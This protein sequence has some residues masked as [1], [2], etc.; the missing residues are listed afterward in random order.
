MGNRTVAWEAYIDLIDGS[1]QAADFIVMGEATDANDGPPVDSYDVPKHPPPPS[2]Y[3]YAFFDDGLAYPY[4]RL[5]YDYRHY[6]DGVEKQWNLTVQWDLISYPETIEFS[7]SIGDL[8]PGP[9]ESIFLR[10]NMGIIVADM[11]AIETYTLTVTANGMETF[12]ITC[13]NVTP[14]LLGENCFYPNTVNIDDDLDYIESHSTI[15]FNDD[16]SETPL[17]NYDDGFDTIYMLIVNTDTIVDIIQTPDDSGGSTWSSIGL[18]DD[19]PDVGVLLASDTGSLIKDTDKGTKQILNYT[20][21][22]SESPYFL[23]C[24]N[25]PTPDGYDYDLTIHR[26]S[27]IFVNKINS[28]SDGDNYIANVSYPVQVEVC[29]CGNDETNIPVHVTIKN[30]DTSTI[31]YDETVLESLNSGECDDVDFTDWFA[32]SGNY[33]IT[34][35]TELLSDDNTDNDCENIEVMIFPG[36]HDVGVINVTKPTEHVYIGES[37]TIEAMVCNYGKFDESSIPVHAEVY[38]KNGSSPSITPIDYLE[39][40]EGFFPPTDWA[41]INNGGTCVWERNDV[42]A[43]SNIAGSG[44]CAVADSDWCG[45]GTSMDTD[46]I[47]PS[48][49]LTRLSTATLEFDYYYD[50]LFGDFFAVDYSIDSGSTWL[51]IHT[52]TSDANGHYT[53]DVSSAC[54]NDVLFKWHY[55]A[56]SWD[57]YAL[58]DNVHFTANP[59]EIDYPISKAEGDWELVFATDA[60][61]ALLSGECGT[62]SL[63]LNWIPYKPGAYRIDVFTQLPTD[64]VPENDSASKIVSVYYHNVFNQRTGLWYG[65]IQ[66]AVDAANPGDELRAIDTPLPDGDYYECV[67]LDKPVTIMPYSQEKPT[68]FA[69]DDPGI[70]FHIDVEDVEIF[71]F[72]IVNADIGIFVDQAFNVTINNCTIMQNN[73]GIRLTGASASVKFNEFSYNN[74]S[75]SYYEAPKSLPDTTKDQ[76]TI[77]FEGFEGTWINDP[78]GDPYMVPVDPDYGAWDIDGL[79]TSTQ[80]GYPQLTHYITQMADYGGYGIP[81]QGSYCAGAWWSDGNGGDNEQDEWLITPEIDCSWAAGLEL[82]L[83]GIWNWAS[84]YG[85]SVKIEVSTDGGQTWTTEADLLHD[86]DFEVGHGGPAGYGWCWNDVEVSIDLSTYDFE[87]FLKIAYHLDGNGS[88]M[89]AINYIDNFELLCAGFGQVYSLKVSSEGAGTVIRDPDSSIYWEGTIV[90]LTAIPE[91]GWMFDHWEKDLTGNEN[92]T[93][94]VMDED[95]VVKAVFKRD[96][97]GDVGIHYNFFGMDGCETPRVAIH[98]FDDNVTLDARWN[99]FDAADGPSG[100]TIDAFTGRPANGLG[101][102]IIGNVTFDH[103]WGINA[104]AEVSDLNV[105]VGE[106]IMFNAVDSFGFSYDRD[107]LTLSYLW[108]FDNM[109]YSMLEQIGYSYDEPGIYHGYLRVSAIDQDLSDFT[110]YDWDYFTIVVSEPDQP[111]LANAD[112]NDLGGYEGTVKEPVIF[113]GTASGGVP[114]YTYEW[115]I[116]GQ[117][118]S[119]QTVECTFNEVG[120]YTIELTVTDSEFN[121]AT[122]TETVYIA[123]LDEL[124]ANAGGPYQTTAD[125]LVQLIGSATGGKAPYTFTWDFGDGSS[126]ATTQNPLHIYDADGIYIV[127]LTVLDSVGNIDEV[128]TTITVSEKHDEPEIINVKGGI[129]LKATIIAADLPVDWTITF[130]GTYL[131][132]RTTATG[133]VAANTEEII[134]APYVFG[135]GNVDITISANDILSKHCALMIGPFIIMNDS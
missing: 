134:Q 85:D 48:F 90:E 10:D 25:W 131:F 115:D 118:L 80:S 23:M 75:V 4:N 3:V 15:G 78:D 16:Y 22:A 124:V 18:F 96:Y 59:A 65:T 24:D 69:C 129:Y 94:I 66:E 5:F 68:L 53:V 2:L 114:G 55:M 81:Y 100:G 112:G 14:P 132:G 108:D 57:W 50:H 33:T 87:P 113:Y 125:E 86:K 102:S 83:Y 121:T 49:D 91:L 8:T 40:F 77:L 107:N 42:T 63:N 72:E 64:F 99:W 28:F 120:T 52:W 98:N 32:T 46:L 44:Y 26:D 111:L 7:W 89:S 56:D 122:D 123:E 20:L 12:T 133:N 76:M 104:F 35:C 29:N 127:T 36:I 110:M 19:C 93:T 92:P 103:W 27:D 106:S 1:M 105:L 88:G 30:T 37:Y 71:G 130:D 82:R 45:S 51:N 60:T 116:N 73:E 9:Y 95:K 67:T 11:L 39:E 62:V 101:H 74:I 117:I 70:G 128:T 47:S 119:G 6:F 34:A 97:S 13:E 84:T 61:I 58:V 135:L 41:L 38:W 31:I 79:C 43:R 21:L 126:P 54:G 109:D 17:G